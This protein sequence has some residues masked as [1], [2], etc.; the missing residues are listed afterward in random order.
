MIR[1]NLQAALRVS[2]AAAALACVSGPP[3][4]ARQAVTAFV[5]ARLIDGSARAPVSNGVL[6]VRGGRIVAVG[7]RE[8]TPVPDGARTVDLAG[9]T[10]I[11]GLISAHAHVSDV[12]GL[13]PRAYTDANTQR[14][15]G[16]FAR[17]GIT[18]VWSLGG[19]QGPAFAAR[20]A[21][22]SAA[23][24][25]ARIFL[26]GEIVTA[27]TP[28]E[29]RAAVARVAGTGVDVIKI[30]VDDNLGTAPK[31][32]PDVY[33]AV[34]DEAHRR[35]VRV[36]AH[37]FYLDDAKGLLK[38]GV[39]VIAHS[40]R[41]REVDAEF[42][43][44]LTSR[45]VPYVPT[46]TREISTFVFEST[47]AFFADP[48][49]LREADPDVVARLREPERQAAMRASASAQ[50]YKAALAV[51][52][53]NLARVAAGGGRIAMGTDSGAFAERFEG[54]FEHLEMEM[55]VEAGMTPAEVLRSATSNAAHAMRRDD[56]GLLVPGRWADF[57]V[58][59]ADPLTDIG[60][61]RR[62]ASVWIAGN[63][64]KLRSSNVERRT[65]EPASRVN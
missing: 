64:V 2:A 44:L 27:R 6:V 19:E 34:I 63:P 4:D 11:P 41:D 45:D 48:F 42:L 29:A 38:A 13:R 32:P 33:R 14:Q 62:I 18:S 59:D 35:G 17:Y 58:L 37:V 36:A 24:D 21:Q 10:V 22:E 7:P 26:A 60:K 49:F 57:V 50:R 46:L 9:R 30:R 39:D 8:T 53:V 25:R 55:M 31:M 12:D 65:P 3:L 20:A 23:L 43:S 5:G 54:Y 47:P 61:T 28:D 51:A 16:V 1:L 52:K 15:L 40:V 56:I